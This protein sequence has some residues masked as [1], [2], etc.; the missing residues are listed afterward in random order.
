[1]RRTLQFLILAALLCVQVNAQDDRF[2]Q[3]NEENVAGFAK[4]LVTSLGMGLN[5]GAFHTADVSSTFGFGISFRFMYIMVPDDQRTFTPTLPDGYTANEST[6]TFYGSKTGASYAGPGGYITFPGGVDE[7]AIPFAMPQIT[8]SFM[9]TEALIRFIPTIK[10]GEE[11]IS[12]FGIGI[13]HSISQ[14]IPLMPLDIAAQV[15]YN[16]IKFGSI[17]EGTNIVF[18]AQASKSFGLFTAYGGLQY[19]SSKFDVNY[20]FEGDPNSQI[21]EFQQDRKISAEIEGDNNFRFIV[22]GTIRLAVIA[23]NADLSLGSQTVVTTGL[24]FEF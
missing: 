13:K 24:S 2:S 23:I 3:L 18:N 12:F 4:P 16:K 15:M 21:P 6:P 19:E 14:Y 20:T 7:S 22:G 11:E 5:S 9:G 8:A 1:M 10:A 17:V